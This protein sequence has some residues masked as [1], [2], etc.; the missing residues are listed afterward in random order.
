VFIT[1]R[2]NISKEF[3]RMKI[4]ITGGA[5]FIGSHIVDS[6]L[7]QGNEVVV[8]DNLSSG[9]LANFENARS[10][11]SFNFVERDLRF[12]DNEEL[13]EILKGTTTV[14]HLS[15][16]ADLRKSLVDMKQDF[17]NNLVPTLKLLDAVAATG[18]KHFIYFS[19]SSIYGEAKVIPTP[20]TYFPIITSLYSASKLSS[21]AFCQAYSEIFNFRLDIFRFSNIIGE[22]CR[23]GVIWDFVHK[24]AG[25]NQ[26]LEVLGDGKQSKEFLHVSD[27]I[28]AVLTVFAHNNTNRVSIYNVGSEQNLTIDE[29][30]NIVSH[31]VT[32]R[33]VEKHFTG[34]KSGWIGDNP[35]VSLD[36]SRVKELG[37]KQTIDSR[38]AIEMTVD[39]TI[40]EIHG[41]SVQKGEQQ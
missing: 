34:G 11:N 32:G 17:D 9:R 15:A 12:I 29:V 7:S 1:K 8:I 4:V 18:V 27:A 13:N 24:L 21:E 6:L 31:R 20:E 28:Q 2:I 3:I 10:N 39:W 22:R 30:A 19:T 37:W 16:F 14:F 23:R 33:R 26:L 38:R 5:G 41:Q 35:I 40:Q 36:I 25:S